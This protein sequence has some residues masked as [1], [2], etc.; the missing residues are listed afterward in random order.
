MS[1]F[2]NEINDAISGDASDMEVDTTD[3]VEEKTVAVSNNESGFNAEELVDAVAPSL[4]EK[5]EEEATEENKTGE[6]D[7]SKNRETLSVE[8][9]GRPQ[10]KQEK[11]DDNAL[12][13]DRYLQEDKDGNFTNSKGDI[14]AAS[15]LQRSY[16]ENLKREGRAMRDSLENAQFAIAQAKPQIQKLIDENKQLKE[17]QTSQQSPQ[18]LYGMEEEEVRKAVE[19]RKLYNSDPIQAFKQLLTNAKVAGI[20]IS[21]VGTTVDVNP[22]MLRTA[23]ADVQK[24]QSSKN[25]ATEQT[26]EK[27]ETVSQED[28]TRQEATAFLENNP[29][30]QPFLETIGKAR[31][32]YP[33]K[34]FEEIWLR[35]RQ[36][37]RNNQ[38][39]KTEEKETK[40]LDDHTTPKAKVPTQK[41]STGKQ[42]SDTQMSFSQLAKAIAEGN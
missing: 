39:N 38:A 15:G 5:T 27:K 6:E 33:D 34:S 31:G 19:L 29:E 1:D 14:V 30:A 35:L 22:A 37:M 9:K 3:L 7:T 28:A 42:I 11:D 26:P 40:A 2:L 41:V 20:D 25:A 12:Y 24:E 17:A 18:D 13:I 8:R 16:F 36:Y 10:L 4:E 23:I 21:R 32:Q